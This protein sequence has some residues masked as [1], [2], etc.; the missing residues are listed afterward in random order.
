[1]EKRNEYDERNENSSIVGPFY[2]SNRE[3]L[4]L[5]NK[6]GLESNV[7][8]GKNI[9]K[10]SVEPLHAFFFRKNGREKWQLQI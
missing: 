4:E 2:F 8:V 10:E 1:M 7:Q 9:T 5:M 3:I 6:N